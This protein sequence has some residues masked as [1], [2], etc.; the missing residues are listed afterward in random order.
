LNP[1]I[2]TTSPGS[3]LLPKTLPMTINIVLILRAEL[4]GTVFATYPT[5][6]PP[7]ST[8]VSEGKTSKVRTPIY[9]IAS[10]TGLNTVSL[11]AEFY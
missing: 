3:R 9:E 7:S 2:L 11:A 4:N 6:L 5:S 10:I 1:T 8:T